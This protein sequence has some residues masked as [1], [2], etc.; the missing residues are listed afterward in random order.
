MM[1]TGTQLADMIKFVLSAHQDHSKIPSKAFRRFDGKTPFGIHPVWAAL[2]FFHEENLNEDIRV[3]GTKAL[4]GH[5][6]T[7]DTTVELPAW[8]MEAGVKELIDALSY[9]TKDEK[10]TEVWN[11]GDE[12][13]L[14]AA[15]DVTGN[16]M[17]QTGF[18]STERRE[19]YA[20]HVQK[21]I[22]SVEKKW[23][24][25]NIVKIAKGLLQSEAV[26]PQKVF[27]RARAPVFFRKRYI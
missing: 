23:G 1:I 6:L 14:L 13:L 2:T 15:Y 9:T 3:R 17:N 27:S 21:I 10:F 8:C 25:L 20:L 22:E 16:L 12:A 19:R 4:L 5:D 7:E 18:D 11:R 24:Q 26:Y